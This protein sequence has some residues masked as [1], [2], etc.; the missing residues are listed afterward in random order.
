MNVIEKLEIIKIKEIT[1]KLLKEL[2]KLERSLN[3]AAIKSR[4][5]GRPNSINEEITR[6]K[7]NEIE[8]LKT[9]NGT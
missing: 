8:K 3:F 6:E 1:K 9:G 5:W 7:I 4:F 2:E